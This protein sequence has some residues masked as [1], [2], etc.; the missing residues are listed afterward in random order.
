MRLC[1]EM[2][3]MRAL[4]R[5]LLLIASA[6][7]LADCTS[8]PPL[9]KHAA[10]EGGGSGSEA[11]TD[12]GAVVANADVIYFPSER[13]ASGAGS[14]PAALLLEAFE[15]AGVPFA[16]GW[17]LIDAKQQPV[18][19]QLGSQSA[20][21]RQSAVVRLDLAGPGRAR[22][23]CRAVLND[24]RTGAVHQVAL[25]LPDS[26]ANVPP[27]ITMHFK[28]PAGG[29]DAF[30][31]RLSAA[32]SLSGRDVAT[33]YAARMEAEQFAA[34]QIVRHF[35]S[36]ASGKLLVFIRSA[37]LE[38]GQGV[39]FYVAQKLPV[40]QL[41]LGSEFGRSGAT[42]LLTGG[43]D[44]ERRRLQIVDRAPIASRD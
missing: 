13:A 32:E 27:P 8:A 34:E 1:F 44:R 18:L 40:R 43:L 15:N 3:T 14:E 29:L 22:A 17:D 36:G 11:R 12:Y 5:G 19:D 39:P 38:T 16:I 6:S 33:I 20:A 4:R 9:P 31:E 35:Q 7:V 26:P 37:D 28:P 25:K 24:P 41:V 2:S 23:H 42:K 21:D 30:A 10:I